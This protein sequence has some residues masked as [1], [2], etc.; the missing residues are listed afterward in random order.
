MSQTSI[1]VNEEAEEKEVAFLLPPTNDNDDEDDTVHFV[2]KFLDETINT[3]VTIA[4]NRRED[5]KLIPNILE[6]AVDK[7]I[8]ISQK[9]AVSCVQS[10]LSGILEVCN[11]KSSEE[12]SIKSEQIILLPSVQPSEE[13]VVQEEEEVEEEEDLE[14]KEYQELDVYAGQVVD[15]IIEE[16]AGL[17]RS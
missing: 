13:S 12:P 6:E 14:C 3:A 7:A 8:T 10:I 5:A 9:E 11:E 15:R 17:Y 1:P 2:P 4:E 16:A